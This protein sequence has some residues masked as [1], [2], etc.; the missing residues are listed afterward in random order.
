MDGELWDDLHWGIAI[1]E[2]T[3]IGDTITLLDILHWDALYLL[4]VDF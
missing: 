3:F 1:S 4:M 2:S